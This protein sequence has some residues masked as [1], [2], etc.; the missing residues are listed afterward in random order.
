MLNNNIQEYSHWFQ[1]YFINNGMNTDLAIFLN[2]F[3]VGILFFALIF[4]LDL[5]IKKLIIKLF[6]AFSNKTKSTFDD[7]LILSNFPR[8]IAHAVPLLI[9]WYFIPVLFSELPIIS[10]FLL[11]LIERFYLLS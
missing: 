4:V 8:H 7:Y 10:T 11:K 6:K 5:I 3:I 2:V 9:S 1:E